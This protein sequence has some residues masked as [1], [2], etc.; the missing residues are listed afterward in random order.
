MMRK[1]AQRGD[2]GQDNAATLLRTHLDQS[3]SGTVR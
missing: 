3:M 2:A 1:E